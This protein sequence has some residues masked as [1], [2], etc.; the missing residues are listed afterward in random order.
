MHC[1]CS[2]S[3]GFTVGPRPLI[4]LASAHTLQMHVIVKTGGYLFRRTYMTGALTLRVCM[5]AITVVCMDL[6]C[7]IIS[8]PYYRWCFTEEFVCTYGIIIM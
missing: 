8:V 1:A 4:A 3:V 7:I 5:Y 6:Y 2:D